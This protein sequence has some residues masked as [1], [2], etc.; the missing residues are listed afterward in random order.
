LEVAFARIVLK[1][2]VFG[3]FAR[4]VV[5]SGNDARRGVS[6]SHG[7]DWVGWRDQFG[8]FAEV[9]SGGGEVELVA[10]TAGTA[11]SEPVEFQDAFEASEEHFDLLSLAP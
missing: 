5:A 10:G 3:G 7:R 4:R 11:K 1:K 9:L 8:E 2:S 6:D